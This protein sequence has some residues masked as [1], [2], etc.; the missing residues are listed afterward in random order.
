MYNFVYY[1]PTKILFGKGMIAKLPTLLDKEQKVLLAYGGGSIKKNGVYDQV[2]QAL[3]GYSSVE[4]SGIEANPQYST[5]MKAVEVVKREKIDFLLA[6]GGG[7]V[8]D[9]VKFIAAAARF[10]GKEPWDILTKGAKIV[11]A[12]PLGCVLTLPATGSESNPNAVISRAETG[13]K[14]AFADDHVFPKFSILDPETTFSLP[15][16]QIANGVVDAFVHV[17]EQY[18]TFD[19]NA[20]LQD[21]FAE[22]ILLTLIEEGPKALLEPLNYDVR[23]NVMWAATLALNTLIGKGVP[24]DWTTHQIGHELTALHGIDHA[25]TLAIILPAVMKHQRRYKAD[26]IIQYGRRVWGIQEGDREKAID[27]AIEKTVD[28]FRRMGVPT[29]LSDVSLTPQD[30][31]KAVEAHARRG[32]RLGEHRHIGAKEIAEILQLAA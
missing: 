14:L 11:D 29:S 5:C 9:A 10:P 26:K 19:V 7:S 4:F 23:A 16:R 8:L 13:E 2:M 24:Q 15:P 20:P 31:Q 30:V 17:M 3:K 27:L 6:V 25:R 22:S 32:S 12:L 21:R 28:F 18:L 1:N